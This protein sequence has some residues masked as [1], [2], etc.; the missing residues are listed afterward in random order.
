MSPDRVSPP[1]QPARQPCPPLLSAA[2]RRLREQKA[3][4]IERLAVPRDSGTRPPAGRGAWP[5]QSSG[6]LD[7]YG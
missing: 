2:R 7:L 6:R 5:P 1:A 3:P 4:V